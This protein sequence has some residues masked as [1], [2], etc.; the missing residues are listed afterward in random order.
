MRFWLVRGRRARW[1][2][3]MPAPVRRTAS[4][5]QCDQD[6][7]PPPGAFDG[8]LALDHV[9]LEGS[10]K[11]AW[12]AMQAGSAGKGGAVENNDGRPSSRGAD[13]DE[14]LTETAT[15]L[16]GTATTDDPGPACA[17]DSS[18][19]RSLARTQQ[20][21]PGDTHTRN[22]QPSS[23]TNDD[24]STRRSS[25]WS[26][27]ATC[28]RLSNCVAG[29]G[30]LLSGPGWSKATICSARGPAN[31]IRGLGSTVRV[32]VCPGVEAAAVVRDS[33]GCAWCGDQE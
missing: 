30:A 13:G 6:A 16:P 22:E 8:L 20:A 3:T 28:G 33:H 29:D 2:T 23:H 12:N 17:V 9:D 21:G 26:S 31:T 14:P 10:R 19:P 4:A 32:W 24:T 7:P 15:V 27:K 18:Q 11:R 1:R 25:A 5:R